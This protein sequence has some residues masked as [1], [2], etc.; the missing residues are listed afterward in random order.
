MPGII[1]TDMGMVAISEDVIAALVGYAAGENFG[2]VGMRG[3]TAKD[4]L[5][6]FAGG[7]NHKR[8]V[9]VT[10][11]EG[12]AAVDIDVFVTV[13]YGVS[14]A[15]VGKNTIETVRY[16]VEEATGLRVNHVAV[17]VEGIRV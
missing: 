17:H 12:G 15:A 4:A 11:L 7:T 10:S 8:G 5:I 9:K 14:I 1:Q 16:R 6:Q 3:K 2:I 13:A